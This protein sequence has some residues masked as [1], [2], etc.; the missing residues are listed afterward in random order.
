MT[1]LT[2]E[3]GLEGRTYCPVGKIFK[4]V[5]V[6]VMDDDHNVKSIGDAGEVKN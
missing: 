2:Q 5:H 3:Y 6:V 4:G 1:D